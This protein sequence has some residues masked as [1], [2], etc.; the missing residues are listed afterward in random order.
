MVEHVIEPT[1]LKTRTEIHWARKVWHMATV[2]AMF[3]V[4]T[5][6]PENVALV[7][8]AV[9]WFLFVPLD[10]LRQN[11]PKLN[12]FLI[13]AFKPIMRRSEVDRLAG[14]TY[15]LSGVAVVAFLFPRPVT[16][17]TLLFLAFADPLAS[18]V[19]IRYGRD[20]I[21]GHKSLQ[22]SLAACVVCAVLSMVY[23]TA[24]N[25]GY[26]RII[27][28]SLIAGVIGALAEAVPIGKLDDN[29]TLP[30]LSALGL[31]V[32]FQIFGFLPL[33]PL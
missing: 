23:L 4:W 7:I 20:K 19:G 15:L 8:L 22:G 28:F 27:I 11:W 32:L 18:Y 9:A 30:V 31:Q 3:L 29:F 2:F 16:S 6:A 17:L 26:D 1:G 14:T 13:H 25:L 10:L 21:F 24:L 5:L 33:L 12:D